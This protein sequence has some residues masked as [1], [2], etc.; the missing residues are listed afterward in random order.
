MWAPAE[1]IPLTPSQRLT[2]ERW[3]R[4]RDTP[5]SVFERASIILA[6]ADGH[7][8]SQIANEVGVSR[9]TVI[10]WRERFVED[11]PAA[12]VEIK[13]GRGR[14]PSIPPETVA[15]IIHDTL[16]STPEN[17]THWSCRTMAKRHAVSSATV[18]RIWDDHGLQPWRTEAFK[19]S[20]DPKFVEKLIDVVG[21]YMNPPDKA[22]VLCVDEKSQIQ[23]L[24][25]T[26]PGLPI[27]P[28]RCGTMTHDYKRNGTTTLFAALNA[29]DGKVIGECL[30]R[31]RHQEFIKFLRRL[32]REFPKEL[33]LHLVVDN[34]GTH[35]HEKVRKW[36]GAH[37]RFQLHFT[38][39]S[40]SWLNQVERWFGELTQKRIRRGSFGSVA[41]LIAAIEE[42]LK[43]YNGDATPFKWT[44]TAADIL[45]KVARCKVIYETLH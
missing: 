16:H 43:A 3:Q 21:L 10:L 32:E 38:P 23:A 29:L 18:Q 34:Y 40:S 42:Y 13:E 26:Q 45:T 17:A 39:T 28:G 2:L 12:L 11:G 44:A 15:A 27:K 24:D 22:V 36:L 9:P 4:G 35:N 5:K 14:K 41:E 37:P 33:R 20:N 25:R 1:P 31:H 6:A 30:A 8:N 7:S 19:L